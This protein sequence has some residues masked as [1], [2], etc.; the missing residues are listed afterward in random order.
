MIV[1]Y[2]RLVGLLLTLVASTGLSLAQF[3]VTSSADSGPGSLREALASAQDGDQIRF[4]SATNG[5]AIVLNSP[6]T[7]TEGVSFRGSGTQN[8]TITGSI[9]FDN[10]GEV[11]VSG[12]TFTGG[13]APAGG[14]IASINT[15]LSVR[16]AMFSGNTATGDFF[17]AECQAPWPASL[18]LRTPGTRHRG[19]AGADDYGDVGSEWPLLKCLGPP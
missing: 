10:A 18:G 5:N 11:S 19:S 17:S 6:V 15:D 4:G 13:S 8:T 9:T 3:T 1:H 7:V 12:I 14:A 2:P 16:N